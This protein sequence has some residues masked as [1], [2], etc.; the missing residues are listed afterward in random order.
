MTINGIGFTG[1]TAVTFGGT[2]A[3]AYTVNSPTRITAT[4]PAHAL[5]QV[6][7]VVTTAWGSSDPTGTAN[8][9]TFTNRYEQTDSHLA[10]SGAWTTGSNPGASGSSWWCINA[11]GA[12]VTANFTGTAFTWVTV[13]SPNYGIAQVTLDGGTPVTVDLYSP[14]ALWQQKVW[15]TTGLADSAHTVKIAWT[16]A[17]NAA[18]T[19]AYIGVDAF[20][21]EGTLK[22]AYATT[23]YQQTDS[24]LFFSGSWITASNPGASGGSWK[25]INASGG[26]VTVPF[27]GT[28]FTWVTVKS[29]N[30]GIAQVTL[31]GGTPVTVDLYSSSTSWQ[32]QVW[33]V[34]DLAAGLHS[35]TIAWTGDKDPAAAPGATYIGVDAFEVVGTLASATRVEETDSRLLFGGAWTSAA[36]SLY[37]GGSFKYANTAGASVTIAFTGVKLDL[38]GTIAYSYGK[39]QVTLDGGA[40]VR[41]D[42]YNPT[43]LYK[44]TMF[45]T[46]LLSLGDHTVTLEWT[47]A[48]NS[49]S[50]NTYVSL[51]AADV[52]G[53]LR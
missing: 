8:D 2:P 38:I 22:Q 32:Q 41:V 7:V 1:A 46:G 6:D 45:S 48:K 31:D 28:A 26:S 15:S 25:C 13:K 39:A 14:T 30:Y 29:P 34:T 5:G 47:G 11:S 20:D 23:L 35:V 24:R 21:V 18:A 16:G 50:S 4:T 51:D 3:A 12:A 9:Y 52:V 33:S 42:L 27:N 10:F 43:A 53:N 36:S 17:K 37:S 19:A 49:A 44:Q 40:P